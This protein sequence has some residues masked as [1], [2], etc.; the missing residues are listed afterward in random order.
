M[1]FVMITRQGDFRTY[2]GDRQP[3][4]REL[5]LAGFHTL[6]EV[7]C[8]VRQNRHVTELPSSGDAFAFQVEIDLSWRVASPEKVVR[9]S[10]HHI[11]Q[12]ILPRVLHE[13]RRISRQYD[14]EKVNEAEVAINE[15]FAGVPLGVEY[16]ITGS[17]L[18]RLSMDAATKRH[19]SQLL[20]VERR[21]DLERRTQQLRLLQE[22]HQGRLVDDRVQRY[23]AIIGAGDINQFA[24]QLA[25]TPEDVPTVVKMLRDEQLINKSETVDFVTKLVK[26]GAIDRWEIDQQVRDALDWLRSST[27]KVIGKPIE[28][29]EAATPARQRPARETLPKV[30]L[31][32]TWESQPVSPPHTAAPEDSNATEPRAD[33]S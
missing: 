3:T 8:G 10:F 2:T 4:L 13:M 12:G 33:G 31:P 32:E 15:C 25:Q 11:S 9:G 23:R 20:D 17:V 29:G 22:E 27:N 21:L 30:T 16:G 6:Y 19:A 28:V 26:S 14:I 24:L 18:V 5:L 7:D 1:A